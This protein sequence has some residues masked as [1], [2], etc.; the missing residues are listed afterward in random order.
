MDLEEMSILFDRIIE[1]FEKGN[2]LSVNITIRQRGYNFKHNKEELKFD[3]IDELKSYK[4]LDNNVRYFRLYFLSGK[5]SI[6]IRSGQSGLLLSESSVV[7]ASSDNEAWCASAVEVV[8]G[9]AQNHKLWYHWIRRIP[10]AAITFMLFIGFANA[11]DL[12]RSKLGNESSAPYVI[13]SILLLM[14]SLYL[15]KAFLLSPS[16]IIIRE[17]DGFI[18]RH[19]PELTFIVS[20]LGVIIAIASIFVK[21]K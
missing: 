15:I 8:T 2:R 18:K 4:E 20:V 13:T 14:F 6:W 3:N 16:M 21:T 19:G 1:L 5:K 11:L 7:N 12:I 17:E 9:F 10:F